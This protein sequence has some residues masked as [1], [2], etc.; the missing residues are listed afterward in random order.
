MGIFSALFGPQQTNYTVTIKSSIMP[1]AA[2]GEIVEGRLPQLK[3]NRIFLKKGEICHYID[4]SILMKEKAKKAF[5]GTGVGVNIAGVNIRRGFIEPEEYQYYDQ[6]KGILYIT[7]KR[8]IFE[9]KTN[10]FDK[11]HSSLTSIT[12]YSNAINMQYGS[13][14]YCIIVPNGVIAENV[15]NI[16][17][18]KTT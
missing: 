1:D 6:V 16:V 9:A 8:T 3:T 17:H 5:T 7:N 14:H 2:I 11:P 15:Y 13:T 18:K 10:G 4:K 12:S